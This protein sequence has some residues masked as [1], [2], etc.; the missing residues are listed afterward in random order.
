[1]RASVFG[2]SILLLCAFAVVWGAGLATPY[3]FD[4]DEGVYLAS[5]RMVARGHPLFTEVFSSQPPVFLRLLGLTFRAMGDTVAVGRGLM[6]GFA[7]LSLAATAWIAWDLGGPLAAPMALLALGQTALFFR[8]ARIVQA[9]VPAMAFALLALVAALAFRKTGG[10][11]WLV[12]G[13]AAFALGC[14]CKLLVVPLLAP[15]LALPLL[16]SEPEAWSRWR[17]L[18][19]NRLTV[20]QVGARVI[21]C[22]L[23]AAGAGLL[24]LA[25]EDPRALYDEAVRYHVVLR[26]TFSLN[27]QHNL[28]LLGAVLRPESGLLVWAAAGLLALVRTNPLAAAWVTLWALAAGGFLV[29]HTPLAPQHIVLVLPPLAVAAAASALWI[30]RGWPK[31]WHRPLLALLVAPL[32]LWYAPGGRVGWTLQRDA[33]LLD[34]P[35]PFQAQEE[36]AI[37][38]IR[39]HARAGDYVVSDEPIQVFRAGRLMPPWLCDLSATRIQSGN[40]SAGQAIAATRP[41]RMVIF[42]ADRLDRL[43]GYREWVRARYRLVR[44]LDDPRGRLKEIYVRDGPSARAG[45]GG[46]EGPAGERGERRVAGKP[47]E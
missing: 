15:F 36:T 6:V 42:W 21:L 19:M 41:A 7:V 32:V 29:E 27:R 16:A 23:A 5:A 25:F 31:A 33:G 40:L 28:Q 12:A 14:L 4:H 18:P 3:A 17:L 24:L 44:T 34:E 8:Q 38:A 2:I 22:V 35:F 1:M 13:G 11:G 37:A 30:P 46:G 10:T 39:R 9:D 20:R 43:P 45:E 26:A 47:P